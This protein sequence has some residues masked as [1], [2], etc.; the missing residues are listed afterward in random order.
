MHILA[1]SVCQTYAYY[2]HYGRER[3][4][5]SYSLYALTVLSDFHGWVLKTWIPSSKKLT[6]K[7]K[8]EYEALSL[9]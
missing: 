3:Q 6:L 9:T 8:I 2:S 4:K 1:V 7:K 5:C